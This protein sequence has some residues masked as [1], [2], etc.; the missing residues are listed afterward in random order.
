MRETCSCTAQLEIIDVTNWTTAA[1]AEQFAAWRESHR[2]EFAPVEE[3]PTVVE[4][5]SSHE[6]AFD[7]AG[8]GSNRV[9][10]GF[11]RNEVQ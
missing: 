5:G 7:D 9:S 1:L 3:I 4:S 8:F 2:H 11:A 6:R 10:I